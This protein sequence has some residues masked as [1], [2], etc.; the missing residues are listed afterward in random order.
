MI[1]LKFILSETYHRAFGTF[2]CDPV[3][4]P[5]NIQT[6]NLMFGNLLSFLADR[7]LTAV[8]FKLAL[9]STAEV[10]WFLGTISTAV[11]LM[12]AG[13]FGNHFGHHFHWSV[14]CATGVTLLLCFLLLIFVA[15]FFLRKDKWVLCTHCANWGKC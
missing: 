9:P 14:G 10:Q 3:T 8:K 5:H 13:R 12:E 2:G 11:L 15:F 6:R 7:F 1:L 4:V